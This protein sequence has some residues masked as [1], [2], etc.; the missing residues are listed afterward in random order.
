M[1]RIILSISPLLVI[2][3]VACGL[4]NH[5]N[6]LVIARIQESPVSFPMKVVLFGD[7]Y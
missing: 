2:C 3:G 4:V 5:P 1:K 6:E 7:N